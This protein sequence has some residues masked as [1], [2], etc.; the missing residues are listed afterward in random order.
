VTPLI[1]IYAIRVNQPQVALL[2]SYLSWHIL[3]LP[4]KLTTLW[5]VFLDFVIFIIILK[6]LELI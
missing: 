2:R 1:T 3:P 5:H 6:K 4:T